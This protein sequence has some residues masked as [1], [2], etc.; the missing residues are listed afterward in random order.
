MYAASSAGGDDGGCGDLEE[1]CMCGC[2]TRLKFII[3]TKS[4]LFRAE[5]KQKIGLDKREGGDL[6]A[7]LTFS[8]LK[9]CI[10]G[11]KAISMV[12]R[13]VG[14]NCSFVK[15]GNTI[16]VFFFLLLAA[17]LYFSPMLVCVSQ[18]RSQT[19]KTHSEDL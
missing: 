2:S 13:S 15:D 6:R 12:P 4:F 11:D 17:L 16:S 7:T 18:T 1:L 8:V 14:V 5:L 9:G 10:A 3:Y 19:I